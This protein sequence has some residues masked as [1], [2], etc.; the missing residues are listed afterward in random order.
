MKAQSVIPRFLL[1]CKNIHDSQGL[2]KTGQYKA[3]KNELVHTYIKKEKKVTLA[4]FVSWNYIRQ[5]PGDLL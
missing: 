2:V 1:T 3:W 5:L 4:L